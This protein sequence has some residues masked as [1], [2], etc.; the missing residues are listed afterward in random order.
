MENTR[1][2]SYISEDKKSIFK[3]VKSCPILNSDHSNS[4]CERGIACPYEHG[5]DYQLEE[6]PRG[7]GYGKWSSFHAWDFAEEPNIPKKRLDKCNK[8]I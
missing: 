6:S 2:Y 4:V 7:V 3:A 8:I 1:K 5:S